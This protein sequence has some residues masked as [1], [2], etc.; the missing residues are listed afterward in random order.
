M[1]R[2]LDKIPALV[3]A[4]R[5]LVGNITGTAALR[6]LSILLSL[7]VMPAYLN[8]FSNSA[9]LGTWFTVLSLLNFLSFF[10][11]GVGN[12][13]RN[14][15]AKAMSKKGTGGA[16]ELISA[17]YHLALIVMVVTAVIGYITIQLLNWER[18]FD[19]EDTNVRTK[20]LELTL[21]IILG[22]VCVQL[23]LRNAISILYGLQRMIIAHVPA[24]ITST[25]MLIYLLFGSTGNTETDLLRLAGVFFAATIAPLLA[26]HVGL[27]LFIIPGMHPRLKTSLTAMRSVG[28]LG[29][30]F[31]SVQLALLVVYSTD[32]ILISTVFSSA[33]VVDY[34][35]HWRIFTVLTMAFQLLTQPF[36]SAV[37]SAAAEGNRAW[38]GKA[39][40]TLYRIAAVG[41]ALGLMLVPLLQIIFDI[42]L[43]SGE[44]VVIW[45]HALAFVLLVGVQLFMFAGTTIA[46][47]TGALRPQMVWMPIA[48]VLKI[49]LALVIALGFD[50]WAAIV[51][52]HAV[53]LIPLVLAQTRVLKKDGYL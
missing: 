31:F 21:V 40:K 26:V 3:S 30:G 43:G 13:L 32:Q 52:A 49:P 7:A 5:I 9:V 10:D 20:T 15:V 39:T 42:W 19:L 35:V 6:G 37:T 34:Q 12:G 38:I 23:F 44:I 24:L 28:G 33:D 22:T 50:S 14:N 51:V 25:I 29:L 1:K 53:V 41:T 46:N 4:N 2:L 47:G 18:I 8:Y 45:W 16:R 48:A 36:W 27:F 17:G 11:F